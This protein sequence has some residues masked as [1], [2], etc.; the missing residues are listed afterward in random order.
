MD[1]FKDGISG[2]ASMTKSTVE[3][4][5]ISVDVERRSREAVASAW[6]SLFLVTSFARSWSCFST[7]FSFEVYNHGGALERTGEF[8]TFVY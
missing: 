6:V 5:V 1:I 3:R 2:T 7:Q 4:S 8:Q